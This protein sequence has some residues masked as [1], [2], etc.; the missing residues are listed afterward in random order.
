M[1]KRHLIEHHH[2]LIKKRKGLF[3]LK[4]ALLKKESEKV[5]YNEKIR[6]LSVERNHTILEGSFESSK[7]FFKIF[8]NTHKETYT[9]SFLNN[10][11]TQK[12]L[13]CC[14]QKVVLWGKKS[15]KLKIIFSLSFLYF[16]FL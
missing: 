7:S 3:A 4:K 9:V 13:P 16:A 12:G 10:C 14:F 11:R 6:N 15:E 1:Q 5:K 2:L 8:C